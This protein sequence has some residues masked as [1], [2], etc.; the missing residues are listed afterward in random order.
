MI[1]PVLP[2]TT[3]ISQ[4]SSINTSNIYF[5]QTQTQEYNTYYYGSDAYNSSQYNGEITQASQ[6]GSLVNSGTAIFMFVA[7][8]GLL[9]F[10]ALLVRFY[11]KPKKSS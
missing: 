7:I 6:P 10:T 8:G 11:K 2:P 5:A 3:V 9:I 1:L 4:V